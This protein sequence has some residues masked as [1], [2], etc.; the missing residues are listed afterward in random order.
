[1]LVKFDIYVLRHIPYSI[2][3]KKK[4]RNKDI[5]LLRVKLWEWVMYIFSH[6]WGWFSKLISRNAG[7][8]HVF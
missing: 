8:G 1:M 2:L 5:H 7:V 6:P 3:Q 4:K